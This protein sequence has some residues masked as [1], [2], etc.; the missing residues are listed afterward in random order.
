MTQSCPPNRSA[1]P[2]GRSRLPPGR[3]GFVF[4]GPY[5]DWLGSP[6]PDPARP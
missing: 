1:P 5:V 2:T 4:V 6:M 3:P